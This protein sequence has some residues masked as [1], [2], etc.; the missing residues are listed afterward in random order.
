MKNLGCDG[1]WYI[2][3]SGEMAHLSDEDVHVEYVSSHY[4][5]FGITEEEIDE[6]IDSYGKE[7]VDIIGLALKHG[8]VR[9]RFFNMPDI[10]NGVFCQISYYHDPDNVVEMLTSFPEEFEGW[11][12]FVHDYESGQGEEFDSIED[13]CNSACICA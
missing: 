9:V 13:Y 6:V 5:D 12:L 7:P 8:N 11:T 3:D 10:P 1:Y 2:K 4:K